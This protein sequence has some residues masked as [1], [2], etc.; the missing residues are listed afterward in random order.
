MNDDV[1]AI[2][3][4]LVAS[5][6]S[7]VGLGQPRQ[8]TSDLLSVAV[9]DGDGITGAEA[10]AYAE[11]TDGENAAV[12]R[13]DRLGSSTVE[14]NDAARTQRE[15]NPVFPRVEALMYGREKRA[16][17][18][19]RDDSAENAR[20]SCMCD[21]DV[22]AGKCRAPGRFD[23]ARH[24][25]RA[26]ARGRS[27]RE[28]P[29]FACDVVD[30]GNAFARF[31]EQTFDV[32]EEEQ[33]VGFDERRDHGR[34][35]IVVAEFDFLDGDGVIFVHDRNA[36]GVEQRGECIAGVVCPAAIGK[37]GMREQN[38]SDGNA[39]FVKSNL[40]TSHENAL[41]GGSGGLQSSDVFGA[42][43]EPE[44]LHAARNGAARYDDDAT[45]G[46]MA[47]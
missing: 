27:A 28:M 42:A 22:S 26:D 7:Y 45:R 35:L 31:V 25:A 46:A 23:F 3:L 38:L 24:A 9:D 5:E 37:V 8:T 30:D 17:V 10:S 2:V 6:A 15:R 44:L 47:V 40:V 16:D 1:L 29:R 21:D 11:D 43:L 39:E 18:F 13:A 32:G 33:Q 41:T 36:S 14:Q 20:F 19:T 34:E 4:A 12:F